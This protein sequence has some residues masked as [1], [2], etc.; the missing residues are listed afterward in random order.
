MSQSRSW[1]PTHQASLA[2]LFA[3]AAPAECSQITLSSAADPSVRK[4]LPSWSP[5]AA[6][7]PNQLSIGDVGEVETS[8]LPHTHAFLMPGDVALGTTFSEYVKVPLVVDQDISFD[9]G[10]LGVAEPMRSI[11]IYDSGRCSQDVPW[12]LMSAVPGQMVAAIGER[13]EIRNPRKVGQI[14]RPI[15]RSANAD[16]GSQASRGGL[17][18]QNTDYV[19]MELLFDADVIEGGLIGDPWECNNPRVLAS[20]DVFIEVVPAT[21]RVDSPC[22]NASNTSG[23]SCAPFVVP[24]AGAHDIQA[25][26]ENIEVVI[27]QR[28]VDAPIGS[29]RCGDLIKRLARSSIRSAIRDQL[30]KG[31]T[32]AVRDW[33]LVRT[34]EDFGLSP[35]ACAS[36]VECNV[37][38]S[39]DPSGGWVSTPS[40][41]Y[42]GYTRFSV[43]DTDAGACQVVIDPER[44]HLRPDRIEV[45]L[46]QSDDDFQIGRMRSEQ[47]YAARFM[48][49]LYPQ[50]GKTGWKSILF[51]SGPTPFGQ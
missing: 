3:L 34:P 46:A 37:V 47:C 19:H 17:L 45:V 21:V 15:I 38:V 44:V 2:L 24:V 31:L 18:T 32:A 6:A 4:T 10:D 40:N 48:P 22:R 5:S 20:F 49:L 23:L 25:R 50:R 11:K 14:V 33:A 27:D 43:C 39:G 28:D 30:A 26:T 1:V 8:L 16:N 29:R 36:D 12:L 42:P 13:D 41:P 35:R 51:E 9:V 7:G